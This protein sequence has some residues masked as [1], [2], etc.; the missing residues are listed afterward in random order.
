ML[1]IVVDN[2]KFHFVKLVKIVNCTDPSFLN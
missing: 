1:L 2:I